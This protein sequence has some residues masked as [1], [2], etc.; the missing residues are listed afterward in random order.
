MS[1]SWLAKLQVEA[2]SVGYF[3]E[4][5][6]FKLAILAVYIITTH[7]TTLFWDS[8]PQANHVHPKIPIIACVLPPINAFVRVVRRK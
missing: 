3:F 6:C 8:V 1:L 7:L 2:L 4:N 5:Y